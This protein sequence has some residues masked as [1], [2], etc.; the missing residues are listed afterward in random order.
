M[1]VWLTRTRMA[2]MRD[3]IKLVARPKGVLKAFMANALVCLTGPKPALCCA[4]APL[5]L[6]NLEAH[7]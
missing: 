2:Q 6:A 1:V 4:L 7:S 3:K 5:L